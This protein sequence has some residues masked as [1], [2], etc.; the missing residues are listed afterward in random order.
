VVDTNHL[1]PPP[2]DASRRTLECGCIQYTLSDITETT[3]PDD[4]AHT[5][6]VTN[7]QWVTFTPCQEHA[8]TNP[9]ER[10]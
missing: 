4:T 8:T 3:G 5:Y 10:T 6:D 9:K 7:S 1:V 2:A